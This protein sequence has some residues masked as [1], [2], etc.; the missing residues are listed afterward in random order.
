MFLHA[1][2]EKVNVFII[3]L[4]RNNILLLCLLVE[5]ILCFVFHYPEEVTNLIRLSSTIS[6][7]SNTAWWSISSDSTIPD[8]IISENINLAC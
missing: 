3:D 2:A 6:V 1:F 8:E 5:V 4:T 7:F